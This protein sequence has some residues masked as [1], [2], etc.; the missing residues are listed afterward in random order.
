MA[1]LGTFVLASE[2]RRA[3]SAAV[4]AA[5]LVVCAILGAAAAVGR[6]SVAVAAPLAGVAVYL[7]DQRRRDRA[8]VRGDLLLEGG[9]L[10]LRRKDQTIYKIDL[11]TAKISGR[12]LKV[13]SDQWARVQVVVETPATEETPARAIVAKLAVPFRPGAADTEGPLP[14]TILVDRQGSRTFDALHELR[15][16]LVR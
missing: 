5:A 14:P 11:A 6:W 1:D 10:L 13:G 16:K 15:K 4:Y 12:T 2:S 7:L 8:L 9:E 3:R